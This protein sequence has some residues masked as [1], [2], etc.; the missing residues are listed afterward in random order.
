MQDFDASLD[1]IELSTSLLGSTPATG[2][3]VLADYASLIGP[4]AVLDFGSGDSIIIEDISD[5]SIL[6]NSFAFG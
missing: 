2:P 5:L 4:D 1:L 3:A 6:A